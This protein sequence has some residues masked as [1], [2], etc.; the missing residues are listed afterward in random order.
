MGISLVLL[1]RFYAFPAGAGWVTGE[2]GENVS[3]SGSFA[4]MIFDSRLGVGVHQCQR[5]A[6]MKVFGL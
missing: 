3:S 2:K 6:G 5:K 4:R 1:S